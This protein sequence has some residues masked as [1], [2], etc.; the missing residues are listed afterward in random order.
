MYSVLHNICMHVCMCTHTYTHTHTHAHT[1]THTYTHTFTHLQYFSDPNL[2]G[3]QETLD[4][5]PINFVSN[6][7]TTT[8]AS[9]H[10]YNSS[11]ALCQCQ[12]RC[13]L[14]IASII[15][16]WTLIV[17]T[18]FY[19]ITCRHLVTANDQETFVCCRLTNS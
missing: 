14:S 9:A 1:H 15:S 16:V 19:L 4:F 17:G 7:T 2:G 10:Y 6:Y 13:M 3:F 12:H 18:H 11:R 5:C 8:S